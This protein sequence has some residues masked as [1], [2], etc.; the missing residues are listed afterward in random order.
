MT[1]AKGLSDV[2]N[3]NNKDISK[4]IFL[5]SVFVCYLCRL[6]SRY[7]FCRIVSISHSD[8]TWMVCR[9]FVMV[10]LYVYGH[11]VFCVLFI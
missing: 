11:Y 1:G 4:Y 3:I 7:F 8:C 10:L 5:L 2:C 9:R 6:R